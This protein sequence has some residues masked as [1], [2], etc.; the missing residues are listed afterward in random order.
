MVRAFSN[1]R[2]SMASFGIVVNYDNLGA[3]VF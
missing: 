1:G 2:Y 3:T